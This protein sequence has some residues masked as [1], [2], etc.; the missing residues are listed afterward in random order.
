MVVVRVGKWWLRIKFLALFVVLVIVLCELLSVVG[1]W[2][3]EAGRYKE[4]IGKSLKVFGQDTPVTE[5]DSLAE[6]LMFFYKYGEQ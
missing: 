6:R 5:P 2:L 3:N 4:P 1:G